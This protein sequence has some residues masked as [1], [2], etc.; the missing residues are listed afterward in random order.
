M[1][2]NNEIR[3]ETM[4]KLVMIGG[5]E[6]GHHS[7]RYETAIFDKEIIELTNKQKPNF[8]FIGLANKYP[9]YY[10]EVMKGIYGGMYG[11]DTDYLTSEDIKDKATAQSKID[12]ANIIYVGGGNTLNLMKRLRK[13]EIDK[14]LVKAY[15]Q[16]KILCGVSAGAI[17]WCRYGQSDSREGTSIKVRGLGLIDL[18]F[19]PHILTQPQRGEYLKNMMKTTYKIPAV[20]LDRV[21]L[22]IVDDKYRV[23]YLAENSKA[24]KCY[25]KNGKFCSEDIKSL[26]WKNIEKL[27]LK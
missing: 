19:C 15:E 16:D 5:G 13:Y 8:L 20:A 25:W 9:D 1:L 23:L 10:Y 27:Y 4:G 14:M 22:E 26:E 17:C 24:E 6:N 7:T 2:V 21:A 18:L 12:K 11:C 3:G